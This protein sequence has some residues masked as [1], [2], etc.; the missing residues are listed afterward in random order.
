VSSQTQKYSSSDTSFSVRNLPS[1]CDLE[2]RLSSLWTCNDVFNSS[3]QSLQ[4]QQQQ[5]LA[6]HSDQMQEQTSLDI[7]SPRKDM[8]QSSLESECETKITG[9]NSLLLENDDSCV[10]SDSIPYTSLP[11]TFEFMRQLQTVQTPITDSINCGFSS[12]ITLQSSSEL[13]QDDLLKISPYLTEPTPTII[14][15]VESIP[16][17]QVDLFRNANPNI[18]F[19]NRIC[20]HR[21]EQNQRMLESSMELAVYPSHFMTRSQVGENSNVTSHHS[22]TSHQ[23][24]VCSRTLE[25]LKAMVLGLIIVD[26]LWIQDQNDDEHMIWG[27]SQLEQSINNC[28]HHHSLHD[29]DEYSTWLQTHTDW[30]KSANNHGPCWSALQRRRRQQQEEKKGYGNNLL[31]GIKVLIP[32]NVW[33]LKTT[34]VATTHKEPVSLLSS[35]EAELLCSLAG[36]TCHV[37]QQDELFHDSIFDHTTISKPL[38]VLVPDSC[39]ED[40]IYDVLDV[41]PMLAQDDGNAFHIDFWTEDEKGETQGDVENKKKQLTKA[42]AVGTI[43]FAIVKESW[44]VESISSSAV[45]PISFF[46]LAVISNLEESDN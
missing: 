12:S 21:P 3:G 5:H 9:C 38:I 20:Y 16:A 26:T 25:Y 32:A 2:R 4:Q 23:R 7:S 35:D 33:D 40:S 36:A 28:L 11:G 13:I 41:F 15:A 43:I 10:D 22:A 14:V 24:C 30:R 8:H 46:T 1:T 19:V 18:C 34:S 27:D 31:E 17:D 29:H 39:T 45:A 37:L 44:L 42:T 6:T